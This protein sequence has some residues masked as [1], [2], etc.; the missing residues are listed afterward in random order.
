[1]E[2]L[3]EVTPSLVGFDHGFSF[4]LR[5]LE[6]HA[7]KLDWPAFLEDFQRRWPTDDDR[8]YVDFMRQGLCGNGLARMGN[9][10]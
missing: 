9:S 10:R 4:P 8:T 7:L 3:S 6:V 5:Y 1:V 2:Q